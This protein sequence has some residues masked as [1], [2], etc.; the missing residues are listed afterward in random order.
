[1]ATSDF[2]RLWEQV[3]ALSHTER[4]ELRE[5]LAQCQ[6]EAAD[7]EEAFEAGLV[8]AGIISSPIHETA[9]ADWQ[10]IIVTG[11]PLSVTL[12]EDRR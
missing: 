3:Q 12:I 6:S 4:Q 2:D 5:L 8:A 11:P 10:P 9:A 1:M 7:S